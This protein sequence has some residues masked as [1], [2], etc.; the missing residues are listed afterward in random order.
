MRL[1]GPVTLGEKKDRLVSVVFV[2]F[3][4]ALLAGVGGTLR[5]LEALTCE[6]ALRDCPVLPLADTFLRL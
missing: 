6:F 2:L 5:V 3:A 4:F 1:C